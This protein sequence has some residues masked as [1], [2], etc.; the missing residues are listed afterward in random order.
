[1]RFDRVVT[2]VIAVVLFAVFFAQ[3]AR[4]ADAPSLT[5]AEKIYATF[6]RYRAIAHETKDG[7]GKERWAARQ[8]L[9]RYYR[10]ADLFRT[11]AKDYAEL[12]FP[13]EADVAPVRRLRTVILSAVFGY[14]DDWR[15]NFVDFVSAVAMAES[16]FDSRVV[17]WIGARGVMQVMPA[18]A[19]DVS[20]NLA[21]AR[22]HVIPSHADEVLSSQVMHGIEYLSWMI[23]ESYVRENAV[24]IAAA[25]RMDSAQ[26]NSLSL[27]DAFFSLYGYA[28]GG[29]VRRAKALAAYFKK[30]RCDRLSAL[31]VCRMAAAM[32]NAGQYHA[33]IADGQIPQNG[34][35]DF[36]VPEVIAYWNRS[37]MSHDDQAMMLATLL[38]IKHETIAIRLAKAETDW[39]MFVT[40]AHKAYSRDTLT[41]L[42]ERLGKKY[43]HIAQDFPM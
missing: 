42:R 25:L 30:N 35:T 41:T 39:R 40:E 16:K 21:A 28:R 29:D 23:C 17:S 31:R 34:Q 9:K 37:G 26:S 20:D 24:S 19:R 2:C 6:N 5:E 4:A 18:T 36:Y 33:V 12:L 10:S 1:M 8:L 32:Y 14:G 3:E 27:K 7:C 22:M 11:Y 43:R 38:R 13:D 15:D